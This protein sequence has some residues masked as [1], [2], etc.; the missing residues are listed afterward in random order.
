MSEEVKNNPG[1]AVQIKADPE[2]LQL[3]KEINRKLDSFVKVRALLWE[4]FKGI[5]DTA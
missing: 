3:L 1:K 2:M 4:A 5:E